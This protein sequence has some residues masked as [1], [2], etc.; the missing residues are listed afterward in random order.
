MDLSHLWTKFNLKPC[1]VVLNSLSESFIANAIS[2]AVNWHKQP[3]FTKK[4][5]KKKNT[6]KRIQTKR[7]RK[8]VNNRQ[9]P[10]H[11]SSDTSD[12]DND[13]ENDEDFVAKCSPIVRKRRK[14]RRENA[15]DASSSDVYEEFDIAIERDL[16]VMFNCKRCSFVT[17]V[18]ENLLLHR[19]VH[20]NTCYTC[21]LKFATAFECEAHMS[22]NHTPVVE[23]III[24]GCRKCKVYFN[25][26][27]HL[28]EH[29]INHLE[30]AELEN[31][32]F[33]CPFC[34]SLF[35]NKTTLNNH[36]FSKHFEYKCTFCDL[37]APKLETLER[38][39]QT[40]HSY[41]GRPFECDFC[42]FKFAMFGCLQIHR[43][44]Y[45]AVEWFEGETQIQDK[46]WRNTV[47]LNI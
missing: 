41:F 24:Y 19:A 39:C 1:S 43:K 18:E 17:N 36:I 45:H 27:S 9:Q 42:D 32:K 20:K 6:P 8:V 4:K 14:H 44:E 31:E 10:K 12:E 23:N 34:Q 3:P 7:K 35:A 15:S 29:F 13:D 2:G 33:V 11:K 25:F 37:L 5:T 38:H 22:E 16:S 28:K 26:E 21:N 40:S 30:N 46:K 47:E